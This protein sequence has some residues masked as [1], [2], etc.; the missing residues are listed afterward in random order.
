MTTSN[1]TIR[2]QSNNTPTNTIIADT[3]SP[4]TPQ[5][6][7]Q[8]PHVAT[9]P[10]QPATVAPTQPPAHNNPHIIPFQTDELPPSRPS[11]HR[12]PTRARNGAHII[13]N[14]M[15]THAINMVLEAPTMPEQH[16]SRIYDSV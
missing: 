6:E 5:P 13:N 10:G 16:H 1:K 11:T 12:Y 9:Q 15:E 14:I 7:P 2:Q 4:I 8:C 3:P